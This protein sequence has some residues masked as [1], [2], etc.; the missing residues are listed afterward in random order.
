MLLRF[1][2]EEGTRAFSL[3]Y[4]LVPPVWQH[5]EGG[6][7]QSGVVGALLEACAWSGRFPAE[8]IRCTK[9]PV[10]GWGLSDLVRPSRLDRRKPA[11]LWLLGFCGLGLTGAG[12]AGPLAL[13]WIDGWWLFWIVLHGLV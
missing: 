10:E 6:Q 3:R 2:G 9:G 8:V 4:M 5:L 12:T 7:G 1:C 13:C 11:Q